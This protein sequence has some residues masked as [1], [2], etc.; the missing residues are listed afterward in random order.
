MVFS[1][2]VVAATPGLDES[3]TASQDVFY[4][5]VEPLSAAQ[6]AAMS[7]VSWREG[8]PV[9]LDDLRYL[10]LSHWGIDG[11]PH[12]GELVVHAR[13]AAEVVQIFQELYR[14]RF[15]I[16]KMRLIEVY[17]GDD[18]AA[19]AD[20]NTSAFNCRRVP[21]TTTWS[22]HAFGLAI[23]INP[24]L[25]PYLTGSRI[26]PLAGEQYLDRT[27]NLSGMIAAGDPCHRAFVSRGWTWG[28]TWRN[29]D[30]QHFQKAF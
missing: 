24:L 9:R 22:K 3:P 20:N 14:A 2:T 11:R 17:G 19:M 28:G 21:G 30:Y 23:D 10:R 1:F 12:I 6:R 7:G 15:P 13:V 27:L 25:N 29:K 4:G 5:A 18:E 26:F 16:A 8:C